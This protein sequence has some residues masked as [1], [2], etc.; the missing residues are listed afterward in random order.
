[1]CSA[2]VERVRFWLF[3]DLCVS[4]FVCARLWL[5]SFGFGCV[6]TCLRPVSVLRL[7]A[8]GFDCVRT[9]LRSVLVVFDFSCAS[10]TIS[11][12]VQDDKIIMML[13]QSELTFGARITCV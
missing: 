4:G 1:M 9:C 5:H 13:C 6:R 11:A 2:S 3:S 10:C 12:T 7:N 8:F